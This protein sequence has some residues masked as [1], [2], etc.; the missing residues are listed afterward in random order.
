MHKHSAV[1]L[2]MALALAALAPAQ[3][4]TVPQ[5]INAGDEIVIGYE[6][7]ARAGQTIYIVIAVSNPGL[8]ITEVPVVLDNKGRGSISYVVPDVFAI[9]FNAPDCRQVTRFP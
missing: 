6:N 7:P 2:T 5:N 4:L 3:S 9:A 8:T 1:G